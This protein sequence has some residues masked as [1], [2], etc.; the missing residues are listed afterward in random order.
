MVQCTSLFKSNRNCFCNVKKWCLIQYIDLQFYE[1]YYEVFLYEQV[2]FHNISF[3][4]L[5]SVVVQSQQSSKNM[6]FNW[7]MGWDKNEYLEFN[8]RNLSHESVA[9]HRDHRRRNQEIN[10]FCLGRIS[11]YWE[12]SYRWVASH[13][14]VWAG[15]RSWVRRHRSL[16]ISITG[17]GVKAHSCLIFK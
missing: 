14:P 9:H 2:K 7:Q 5:I 1:L 13:Y 11:K 3:P 6:M 15:S 12:I 10:Q 17:D 8:K 4:R 16:H